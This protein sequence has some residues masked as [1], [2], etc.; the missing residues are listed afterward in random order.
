MRP[1]KLTQGSSEAINDTDDRSKT[2]SYRS[3]RMCRHYTLTGAALI[4][5]MALAHITLNSTITQPKGEFRA[6]TDRDKGSPSPH[7]PQ[8]DPKSVEY[9]NITRKKGSDPAAGGEQRR[10]LFSIPGHRTC[11][12]HM[13]VLKKTRKEGGERTIKFRDGKQ[14]MW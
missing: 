2:H 10:D 4:F 12:K 3:S 13:G 9:T 14:N 1:R 7:A 11:E 5:G 8:V 6:N